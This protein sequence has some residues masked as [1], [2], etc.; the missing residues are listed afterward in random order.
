[1]TSNMRNENVNCQW[2]ILTART[3]YFGFG[4]FFYFFYFNFTFWLS[5][6]LPA[7]SLSALCRQGPKAGPQHRFVFWRQGHCEMFSH[8]CDSLIP[9][10]ALPNP[11][12]LTAAPGPQQPAQN[13]H[14]AFLQIR[15]AKVKA[16]QT[17][18]WPDPFLM[19]PT[20]ISND[21]LW[22]WV[23]FAL[24]QHWG[25][26]PSFLLHQMCVLHTSLLAK[27]FCSLN[28]PSYL[29]EHRN[30]LHFELLTSLQRQKGKSQLKSNKHLETA[31][32]SN[33]KS[34][35]SREWKLHRY[36]CR[37]FSMGPVISGT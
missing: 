13:L 2:R 31:H 19:D 8:P 30:V 9:V 32:E 5:N 24:S 15:T 16:L 25:T 27:L 6:Q 22:F 36:P 21:Q 3:G 10:H 18:S 7:F 26:W 35:A 23:L 4:V 33:S 14:K 34:L 20:G 28:H 1:M 17:H 37:D 29:K 12:F 11:A